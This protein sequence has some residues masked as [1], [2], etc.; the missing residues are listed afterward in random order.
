MLTM[1]RTVPQCRKAV[2]IPSK[3]IGIYMKAKIR[4]T[5]SL[6]KVYSDVPLDTSRK[7]LPTKAMIMGWR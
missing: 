1:N 3:L 2:D 6:V 4:P 5:S 7:S